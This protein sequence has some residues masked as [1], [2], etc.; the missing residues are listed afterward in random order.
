MRER[1]GHEGGTKE[2][3]RGHEGSTKGGTKATKL[4]NKQDKQGDKT[5]NTL[6]EIHKKYNKKQTY[7]LKYN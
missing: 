2:A 5:C 4:E 7:Y 6:I 1:R 3:R